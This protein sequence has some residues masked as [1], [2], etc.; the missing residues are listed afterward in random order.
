MVT[1]GKKTDKQRNIISTDGFL[2]EY[3]VHLFVLFMDY[4]MALSVWRPYNVGW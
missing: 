1:G 2:P 4:L 3:I